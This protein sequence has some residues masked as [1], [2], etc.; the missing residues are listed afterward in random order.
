MDGTLV[1]REF[2][3]M[4]WHSKIP[5]IYAERHGVSVEEAYEFLIQRYEEVG[6]EDVRWYLPSY[7]FQ[8][9]NLDK[10]PMNVLEQLQEELFIY[11]DAVEVLEEL[12]EKQLIVVSNASR[13][14]LKVE[15]KELHG[16]FSKVYSCVSDFGKVKKS[17]G[18]YARVCKDLE[19][20][21]EEM[22]HI[23]DDPTFDYTV[24]RQIGIQA[25]LI[26]RT[27]ERRNALHDLRELLE[28]L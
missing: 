28:Y 20:K 27:K 25:F 9:F 8:R 17:S 10:T 7:W 2:A 15:L 26:D 1:D 18:V 12:Q 4:F 3:D 11:A 22:V 23:G 6:K 13:V 21:A 5:E 16:F 14:F 19:V 24:P